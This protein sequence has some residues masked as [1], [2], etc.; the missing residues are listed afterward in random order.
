MSFEEPRWI[1]V[2]S[3]EVSICTKGNLE[4]REGIANELTL[5]ELSSRKH[6]NVR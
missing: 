6:S 1:I 2:H 4:N 5:T 3:Q